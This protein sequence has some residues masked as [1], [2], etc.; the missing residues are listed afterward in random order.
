MPSATRPG[1]SQEALGVDV[2]APGPPGSPPSTA[3]GSRPR[4]TTW[5]RQRPPR[6]ATYAG[7]GPRTATL[8][9]LAAARVRSSAANAARRRRAPRRGRQSAAVSLM[10]RPKG[11]DPKRFRRSSSAATNG[12]ASPLATARMTGWSGR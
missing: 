6:R 10:S 1:R 9:P 12:R 3:A 5:N 11:G 2:D 8:A 7:T 4:S